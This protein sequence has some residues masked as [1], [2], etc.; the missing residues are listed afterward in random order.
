MTQP[1]APE[2]TASP[3]LAKNCT[4]DAVVA[5][6]L[7]ILGVTV[8]VQARRLGASW[9]SDGP[10][11]GYF[12]FYIGLVLS[13]AACGIFYQATFGK[14]RDTDAFVDRVQMTR[15]LSVFLPAL[16]YVGVVVF[17]GLYVASAIYIALFMIF[18]GKY[19]AV[20]SV[21]LSV[22]VIAFFF[23]MFEI[24]FKVP[25]YK[26]TLEPLAFLGY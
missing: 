20:K 26:G 15:V 5:V 6:I 11:S 2:E 25:L 4:V 13:L 16:L 17:L 22:A 19:S 24:W 21:V 9:T 1:H 7:L 8:I 10:G 18:L 14:A 12:P 3:T 23:T